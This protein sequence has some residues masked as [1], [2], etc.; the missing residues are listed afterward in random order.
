MNLYSGSKLSEVLRYDPDTDK[1]EKTGDLET[2]REHH[3]ASAVKWETV[4]PFC[5]SN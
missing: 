3:G 1:W 5:N 2:P 4:A